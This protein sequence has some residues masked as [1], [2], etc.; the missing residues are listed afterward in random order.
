MK[1]S[2]R[3]ACSLLAFV[4]ATALGHSASADG[5]RDYHE[6]IVPVS[7]LMVPTNLEQGSE[8]YVI[9]SGIFPNACYRLTEPRVAHLS[10]R[11]HEM[12]V[13]AIVYEGFC[14]MRLVPFTQK[15]QLGRLERGEH[16]LRVFNGDGTYFEKEMVIR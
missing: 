9:A 11:V 16:L 1:K 15:I 4:S 13:M 6:Q 2:I 10:N 5:V 14:A 7:E 12:A 3:V 8:A